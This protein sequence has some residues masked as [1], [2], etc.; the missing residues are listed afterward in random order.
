MTRPLIMVA[1]NGAR[2]THADHPA[3][4]VTLSETIATARSCHRAGADALHLHVRDDAGAHSLDPGRY[5]EALDELANAVPD[6]AV[7]ITTES[8]G[9]FDVPAQLNT[10]NRVA[11][12]WA[13]ISIREIA[14]APALADPVYGTCADNG[15]RVQHIL[16]DTADAALLQAWTARGIVRPSQSDVILVLG[17]Y[18]AGQ[19]SN[20]Q[21]IAPLLDTLHPGTNWMLCAFGAN[22]HNCLIQA[23][24]LGGDIRVGFENSLCAADGTLYPDNAASVADLTA[25]LSHLAA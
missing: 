5:R 6:M 10:L 9:I 20:P 25:Q 21:E 17:R 13:S 19:T 15:T 24:R 4:P 2:R 18:V 11:P 23:A 3:L 1:P 12:K 7:Q 16:Y 8:A 22:E 14:R